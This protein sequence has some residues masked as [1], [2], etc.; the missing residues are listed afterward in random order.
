MAK[1]IGRGGIDGWYV[2]D[3]VGA[4]VYDQVVFR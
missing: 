3:S 4:V 1:A 2:I